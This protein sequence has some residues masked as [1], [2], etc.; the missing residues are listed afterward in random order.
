NACSRGAKG[1]GS[2]SQRPRRDPEPGGQRLEDTV[3]SPTASRE[4]R[5]LTVHGGRWRASPTP[6]PARIREIVADSLAEGPPQGLREPPAAPGP[7]PEEHAL[8][9]DELSRLEDLLAQA[10]AERDEL[11]GRYHAVSERLQARLET[12]TAQLRR[13]ELERSMD[14]EE[15]LGRLEAAEQRSTGLSQVNA[16]LREQLEQMRKAHDRLAEELARTTGSVPRL[17]AELELREAGRARSGQPQDALLQRQV[18]ALRGHLAELRAATEKGLADLRADVARMARRLHTACLNLGSNLRLTAGS[19]AAALEQQLR[20]KVREMLQLQGRWAAEKVALQ[21]RLAEQTLLVEKLTEQNA[22]KERAIS[23]LRMDMQRLAAQADAGSEE[24]ARS[25]GAEGEEVQGQRRSPLHTGSLL[26]AESPATLDSAL[27]AL[28]A[29]IQKW[30]QRE[31]ELRQ[32][33]ESSEARATGLQKQLSESQRELQASRSLLQEERQDLLGKLEAQS[34][35]AQWSRVTSELLG[36]EKAALEE[37]VEEL[38]G[39]ATM[40]HAEKQSVEARNAEL[41]RSL[42]QCAGQKEALERQGERGRRALESSQGRLEQLEG[43]VSGLKTELVSAQEALDS[44]RLQRDILESE[45]EGLHGALARA[46]SSKADL[47]LLV[48]R[49]KAEGVEQRDSLAKMAAV[50][51]AL[52][53]DKCSLNHLVLQLEQERDELRAQQQTLVQGQAGTREQLAQAE[54]QVELLRAERRGLQRACGRLEER[55]ERLEGQAARLRRERAQLQEQVGHVTCKKQALEK[56]LAQSLQDQEA[57]MAALQRALQEKE[58]L[59]EERAQLLAKQEA[60]EKQG[61]LMA[62]EAADLRAERDALESSLFEAQQLASQLQAQQ[63]QLEGEARSAR[64]AQ[65]ALQ[66]E[67]EQLQ[68]VREAQETRLRR[69]AAQQE[70]DVQLALESQALAHREDLARLQRE[71]ETLSLSLME[72]KEAAARRLKQEKELVAKNASRTEALK[73]QVQSLRRERDEGRLQLQLEKQQVTGARPTPVTQ[74]LLLRDAELSRLRGELQLVRREAQG[75]QE[76]AE[77]T[78]SAVAAELKAL[79]AQF[80]DAISAHQTEARALRETL[81]ELA[82]QRSSAGREAE[83]LRAQLDEAREALAALRQELQG[84]E[85]TQE[86]LQGEAH[87]ARRALADAAREKDALR[88]S[89]TELRAALRRAEQEKASFKRSTEEREQKVLVLEE[90]WA[91]AQKQA[92]EL[93]AGLREADRAAVDTQRQLQELRR[94]VRVMT[95]EVEN[96]RKSREL[97]WLQTRGAQEPSRQEALALQTLVA[98]AEA[99]REDAQREVGAQLRRMLAEVE[100]RAET[101][102]KGLER[103]LCK[104]R[105]SERAL[106]AE[107]RGVAQK[108]QQANG[109]ADSLQVLPDGA[110]H[111]AHGLEQELARAEGAWREAEGQR[112]QLWSTLH[113]GVGLH[114]RSPAAS[115]EPAGPPTRGQCPPRPPRHPPGAPQGRSDGGL[116]TSWVSATQTHGASVSRVVQV[117]PEPGSQASGPACPRGWHQ[118]E[119]KLSSAQAPRALLEEALPRLQAGR[120]AHAAGHE[121]WRLP[122]G[123]THTPGQWGD[124]EAERAAEEGE[125]SAVQTAELE[126]AHSQRLQELVAQHQRL[127]AAETE[128]LHGARPQAAQAPVSR[129][130]AQQWQAKVLEGQVGWQ[131]WTG[132]GVLCLPGLSLSSSR[133]PQGPYVSS[134]HPTVTEEQKQVTTLSMP[135]PSP[136]KKGA[137][138]PAV[139]GRWV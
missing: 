129:E 23:S 110:C 37:V 76:Q 113:P 47:E 45:R 80:E 24:L 14:L 17:R 132:K 6:V 120:P 105:G 8:L 25:S 93:R 2:A 114:G 10:G 99:A 78:V 85:E 137:D 21:A 40:S 108:L 102:E 11:A 31:Q 63:E 59:S 34:R 51:E 125:V 33:L 116:S 15:A 84:S 26:R 124:G 50:T 27:W 73:E 100:A 36:R 28:R 55:L 68:S 46:E 48:S 62:E 90:A 71:K 109:T 81:R 138:S 49:L 75:Q 101:R 121:R 32:Q 123:N 74:A 5:A 103:Q 135:P 1:G 88:D 130:R 12:T 111:W 7:G 107:L 52:A 87:D 94:Q 35:E 104:S 3:L 126:Q 29:A 58:A 13:S 66:V 72:E 64:L 57:Q 83:T 44:A 9:Q 82:A 19:A 18:I 79:Q 117:P 89:N 106:W 43:T 92:G 95:L 77:A 53:Q 97:V 131:G 70:R 56:Q 118:V 86:G 16:L 38:R 61:Q 127:Q 91:A 128:R 122:V 65:Q 42:Q 98:E 134:R 4:D 139:R 60:L 96:Q 30:R 41:Q 119:G 133:P 20:D 22:S 69:Q 136:I 115:P 67:L 39:E 54:R 112:G